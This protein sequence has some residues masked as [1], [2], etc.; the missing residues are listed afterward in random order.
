MCKRT[1]TVF[2]GKHL[3]KRI[4]SLEQWAMAIISKAGNLFKSYDPPQQ[5]DRLLPRWD[6]LIFLFARSN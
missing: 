5:L 1:V 2:K 3:V 6:P 4:V